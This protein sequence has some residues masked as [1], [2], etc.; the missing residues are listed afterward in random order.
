M[1]KPDKSRFKCPNCEANYKLVRAEAGPQSLDRQVTCRSCGAP[2]PG[3]EG[4]F[5]LKYFLVDRPRRKAPAR[6]FG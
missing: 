6:R 2:F 3:R 1:T 4:G 5:V